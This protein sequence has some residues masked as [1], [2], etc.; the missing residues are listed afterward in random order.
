VYLYK[1]SGID[2]VV[3]DS[4]LSSRTA[5]LRLAKN[6]IKYRILQGTIML[7]SGVSIALNKDQIPPLRT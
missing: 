4:I 1:T 6:G 5:S 2:F 7:D 3:I